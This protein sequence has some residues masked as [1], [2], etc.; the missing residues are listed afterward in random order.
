MCQTMCF[1]L[2]EII[3]ILLLIISVPIK[4]IYRFV[5]ELMIYDVVDIGYARYR[6]PFNIWDILVN[7][8]MC[9]YDGIK[10]IFLQNSWYSLFQKTLHLLLLMLLSSDSVWKSLTMIV[11]HIQTDHRYQKISKYISQRMIRQQKR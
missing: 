1:T 3:Y 10:S 4:C 2:W 6:M 8:P 11:N 5:V 7:L 9:I